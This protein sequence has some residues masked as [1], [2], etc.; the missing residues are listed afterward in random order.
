MNKRAL[1]AVIC[2]VSLIAVSAFGKD[3]ASEERAVA[4][5]TRVELQGAMDVN[6]THGDQQRVT[7]TA[8]TGILDKLTT[9]VKDGILVVD[10]KSGLFRNI[11]VMRV[12]II[13]PVL[14]GMKLKG[15]GDMLAEGFTAEKLDLMLTGSGDLNIK[16]LD[17]E[18]LSVALKGSGDIRLKGT[19]QSIDVDLKGSGD[20]EADSMKCAKAT[21]NLRGSG[22]I[23]LY[24]RDSADLKLRGSGDIDIHGNPTDLHT[25]VQGSGDITRR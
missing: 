14:D 19:C 22:D 7:V 1:G 20:V 5:F 2:A 6:I 8:D 10:M 16:G 3:T 25:E 18:L 13:L 9:T 4:A 17:A 11:K 15:S 24:A 23:D 21:A 12:D